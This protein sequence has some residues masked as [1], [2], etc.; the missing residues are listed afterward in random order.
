M[1]KRRYL[2]DLLIAG[3]L[4]L[5]ALL[6]FLAV[7][8]GRVKGAEAVVSVN[9]EEVGRY[10]LSVAGTFP[11]NGGS[12]I[13][14]I[15]DGEARVSEADCPDKVCVH[16]RAISKAGESIVCLPNHVIL[17]ITQG[18]EAAGIDAISE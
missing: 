11:L 18:G 12:N 13:L 6:L 10:P 2:R 4:L 8:G 5:A 7:R 1:M 14:V 17:K 9:G 16:S 3:V 15:E